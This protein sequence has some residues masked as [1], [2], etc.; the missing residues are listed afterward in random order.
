MF[1]RFLK[2]YNK[3]AVTRLLRD[4][5]MRNLSKALGGDRGAHEDAISSNTFIGDKGAHENA[6]SPNALRGDRES[7]M[8]K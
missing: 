8:D 4:L 5:N 1:F 2:P 6:G 3:F 7:K